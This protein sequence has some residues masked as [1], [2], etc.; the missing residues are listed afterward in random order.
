[1]IRSPLHATLPLA[2]QP[3][4]GGQGPTP[5]PDLPVKGQAQ[6]STSDPVSAGAVSTYY[7]PGTVLGARDTLNQ[8]DRYSVKWSLPPGGPSWFLTSPGP[9]PAG[10][11]EQRENHGKAEAHLTSVD[12]PS[13]CCSACSLR[14][15]GLRYSSAG[16]RHTGLA[17]CARTEKSPRLLCQ[18]SSL[19]AR[20][21]LQMS[22]RERG[23]GGRT[24]ER[25]REQSEAV[26][27]PPRMPSRLPQAG[28]VPGPP[29]HPGGV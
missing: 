21:H 7:A 28:R 25:G 18:V 11:W 13:L 15:S 29:E 10:L 9:P 2:P 3:A 17:V 22:W 1:M 16:T 26:R 20:W 23:Q 5:T 24:E 12:V 4:D 27:S 8:S 14:L 6:C 19:P